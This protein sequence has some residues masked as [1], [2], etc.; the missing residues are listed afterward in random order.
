MKKSVIFF[1]FLFLLGC[2]LIVNNQE[3][4]V[5]I[6]TENS[7]SVRLDIHQEDGRKIEA[8]VYENL[9]FAYWLNEDYRWISSEV[10]LDLDQHAI[11]TLYAVYQDEQGRVYLPNVLEL[12][13]NQGK[14]T[15][16]SL[17]FEV[18]IFERQ[19]QDS[20]QDE[21]IDY[22]QFMMPGQLIQKN[23]PITLIVS[24]PFP[25]PA[26]YEFIED[27]EYDGPRLDLTRLGQV[28]QA[29]ELVGGVYRGTGHAFEVTY[30]PGRRNVGGGCI[31]GDTTVFQYP[32]EIFNLIASNAKSTRYFNI[33]TPETFS[34]GEEPFGFLAT[35]YVCDVLERAQSIVLQTDP[36]DNL[37]D[38]FGR[39]LAWIWVQMPGDE[40]YQLLNYK[41][42]RRGLGEVRY[43]F[44]AG[45]TQATIYGDMTYTEWMFFAQEQAKDEGL[46]LF[47]NTLDPYWDYDLNQ[48]DLSSRP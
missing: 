12:P 25:Y 23:A 7:Q 33:D 26:F 17:G 31:D 24:L 21:I 5:L 2:Q 10:I 16:E 32:N 4:V 18:V 47:G 1:M 30:R 9:S 19:I 28:S 48:P 14:E 36:G 20:V 35:D 38:R 13:L 43:L 46:G 6:P 42:V 40:E 37:L 15:L 11:S 44:G 45:E 8:P 22:G 34:S 3:V 41:V 27:V 39:F 29:Y